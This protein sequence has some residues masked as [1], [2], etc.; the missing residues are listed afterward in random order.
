MP[1]IYDT[2][3]RAIADHWKANENKYPQKIVLTPAQLQELS[4]LCKLGRLALN[5]DNP[6]D[7]AKFLGVAIEQDPSTPGV[8]IAH[9]GSEIAA[10]A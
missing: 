2:V 10:A 9:D 8:L 7:E 6:V 3:T 4:E 1:N 5:D